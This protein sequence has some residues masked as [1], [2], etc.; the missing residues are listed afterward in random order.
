MF[1]NII[2]GLS[3]TDSI[4]IQIREKNKKKTQK[5]KL[6]KMYLGLCDNSTL[7]LNIFFC[8]PKNLFIFLT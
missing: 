4:I 6:I 1:F 3:Y 5:T 2:Y 8:V 7:I